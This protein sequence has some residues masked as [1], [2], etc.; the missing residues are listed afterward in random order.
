MRVPHHVDRS[1]SSTQL[2][3][4]ASAIVGAMVRSRAVCRLL[5][6]VFVTTVAGT[7]AAVGADLPQPGTSVSH[8]GVTGTHSLVDRRKHPGAWLA[9]DPVTMLARSITARPPLVYAVDATSG[10]DQQL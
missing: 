8:S 7:S 2:C 10:I 1:L 5:G 4:R 9:Y 6:L 3:R